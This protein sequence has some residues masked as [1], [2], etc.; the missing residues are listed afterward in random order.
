MDAKF[1]RKRIDGQPSDIAFDEVINICVHQ[2][3][4][5]RV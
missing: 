3:S 4:L 1:A 5:D 2:P